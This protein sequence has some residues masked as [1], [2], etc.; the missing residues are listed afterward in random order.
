MSNSPSTPPGGIPPKPPAPPRVPD[1]EL[2]RRIGKGAYGEVWLARCALGTYR[3]VKIVHRASFDHDRPFEREFE[4]IRK[5]EP[6]SRQHD[7]QV[8][9]LH[10]GRNGDCFYYVMELADDQATG[11]QINPDNYAPRTL[12]SDLQFHGRLPFEECVRI[13]IALTTALEH[14]HENGLVHRDVKPSNIIFVN[15]VPKL[16]D[17]GLVTGVDATRSFVGTEGFA[18]PEGAG[19]PQADLFSLGKVLYETATGKDRQEFPELPTLL[20]ELPDREGLMELNAVI[21]H[22]C[23]HDPKDRYASAAAMRADLELLQSGK[24]LAR[25][26]RTEKRLRFVQRAGAVV[27]AIAAMIAAGWLW[28]A[29]QTNKVATLAAENLALAEQAEA[30]ATQAEKNAQA[31]GERLYAADINLAFQALQDDNLRLAQ[32][33]LENHVPQPGQPDLRGF[34]WRYLWQRTRSEELLTFPGQSTG[35]RVLAMS[36]DGAQVAVGGYEGGHIR[37]LDVS[38]RRV[39][40]TLQDTNAQMSL[41]Y[42]PDGRSLVSGSASDVRLWDPRLFTELRR[43]TN[44]VAPV[45][46]SPDGRFLLTGRDP[47]VSPWNI[48]GWDDPKKLLVWDTATWTVL[49]SATFPVSGRPSGSRDLYLQVAFGS[50]SRHVAVLTGGTTRVLNCPELKEVLVLPEDLPESSTSRPFLALSPDNRTLAL[51]SPEGYGVRLWDTVENRELRILPGHTDH[52]FSARFSPDGAWLVTA[53]PDQTVKLWQVATGEL[54]HTFRG[55][56]DEVIDVVFSADGTRLASLGITESVVKLWD[57]RRRPRSE[58]LPRGLWPQGF[59]PGG[60]MVVLGRGPERQP[61]SF[62]PTDFKL[63]PLAHPRLRDG[64]P[65]ANKLH[66]ISPDGRL[67]GL[68]DQRGRMLEVWDRRDGTLKCTVHSLNRYFSFDRRGRLLTTAT[69]NSV[70]EPRIAVWDLPTGRLKWVIGGNNGYFSFFPT[71]AGDYLLTQK[72]DQMQ[73][74]RV[75]EDRLNPVLNLIV[76][77]Y[78]TSAAISPDGRLLA[79]GIGDITLRAL[80]AGQTLGVLRGHT[81]KTVHLAFSPDS[82]TLASISDDHTT[83]LW[84]VATQRELLR[85]PAATEDHDM[86]RVEFSPDGRALASYRHDGTNA[87]TSLFY[88]PSLAEIAV[89]EGG[90]YRIPAGADA[91]TWLN[92]AKALQ[93]ENRWEEALVACDEVLRRTANQEELAWLADKARPLRVTALKQLDRLDEAGVENCALQSIPLRKPAAPAEA[94]DLSAFYNA[95]LADP[96][97]ADVAANDLSEL[98]TGIQ[99]FAGTVFDVRGKLHIIGPSPDREWRTD[100]QSIDGIHVQRRL[101][102]LHFLQAAGYQSK[103]IP[104][105]ERIGCFRVHFVNGRTMEIPLRYNQNTSDWWELGHLPRELPEAIVAWR[106]NNPHSRVSSQTLRLFKLTW[107]NPSPEVEITTLDFVA[108]HP[109]THPFLIALTVE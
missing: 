58:L 95:P 102:R 3:A 15:G 13:G 10:V 33:L 86:F 87:M 27:T 97:Q 77:I 73:V 80:P 81:R 18:A 5:F 91:A 76:P 11:G 71:S 16:A 60:Q 44:A 24:S 34:E 1:H 39:V 32:S 2:L 47:W 75:E 109:K 72:D 54:L 69:T 59:E 107:E 37:L 103:D 52:I 9:I 106:G 85:F 101:N 29:R 90:D 25:L 104:V 30:S 12:K 31:A 66:S 22:A 49:H 94:I 23:R 26:H 55:Q 4:G 21:A 68:W 93:R 62:D 98:P 45:V 50:D 67:H 63:A 56:A 53:S 42:S 7:S 74:A 46:F 35:S 64:F 36:P 61:L 79:L 89:A 8:D 84:H 41:A 82:R 99:T 19:T 105:G 17:I 48:K 108:E 65:A 100:P 6:I 92:V 43:F 40:A 83:R 96:P 38:L 51:P 70:G 20:R 88:A 78:L 28:Q 57:A 14:L